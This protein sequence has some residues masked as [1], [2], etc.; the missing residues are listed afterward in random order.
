M[1]MKRLR[2]A[3]IVIAIIGE[4][5]LYLFFYLPARASAAAVGLPDPAMTVLTQI[6]PWMVGLL[7]LCLIGF[8]ISFFGKKK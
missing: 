8:I 7:G 5:G 6:W 4:I 3:M 1:N 2:Y